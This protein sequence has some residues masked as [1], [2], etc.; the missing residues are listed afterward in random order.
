[1]VSIRTVHVPGNG[2]HPAKKIP[3][4][5]R[6][7]PAE[8]GFLTSPLTQ[9]APKTVLQGHGG[10]HGIAQ[11]R[12]AMGEGNQLSPISLNRLV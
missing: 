7:L 9:N 11:G 2:L 3:Q 5:V 1:M 6:F 10:P 4:A 12:A 8:H